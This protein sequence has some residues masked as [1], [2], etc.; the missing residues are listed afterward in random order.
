MTSR[1]TIEF[2]RLIA[3][4]PETELIEYLH[5]NPNIDIN[6]SRSTDSALIQALIQ[7]K[8]ALSI[9]LIKMGAR[10]NTSVLDGVLV[11]DF[12]FTGAI[13][14]ATKLME[15]LL[16][17]LSPNEM[18]SILC[19]YIDPLYLALMR[20]LIRRYRLNINYKNPEFDG[21]TAAMTLLLVWE[22][23]E[24]TR[25]IFY[26]MFQLLAINGLNPEVTDYD[27][28]DLYQLIDKYIESEEDR[29]ILIATV[30]QYKNRP[31]QIKRNVGGRRSLRSFR[32]SKI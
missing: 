21:D 23:N 15:A 20:R 10:P 29:R 25:Q 27:G 4:A 19:A 26:N 8:H 18:L 3:H 32:S 16:R 11:D 28:R 5:S 7:R 2:H 24:D 6:Y 12:T 17:I 9:E 14:D 13:E 30:D 31:R 22:N 1:N